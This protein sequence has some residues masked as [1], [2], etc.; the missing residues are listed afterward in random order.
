[1]DTHF[2]FLQSKSVL[3][4]YFLGTVKKE[5][6]KFHLMIPIIND[7]VT[8]VKLCTQL[9]AQFKCFIYKNTIAH[10]TTIHMRY[11]FC[12]AGHP[13]LRQVSTLQ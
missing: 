4:F 2:N 11:C 5:E 6:E 9:N 1:M 3:L 12:L 10:T 8:M 7:Y 13:K